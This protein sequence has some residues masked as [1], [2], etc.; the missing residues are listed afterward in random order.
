MMIQG[1][2]GRSS[3]PDY[4][5]N[6]G[7]HQQEGC[8]RSVDRG[9]CRQGIE[10]R[11]NRDRPRSLRPLA[12]METPRTGTGRPHQRPSY[13]GESGGQRSTDEVSELSDLNGVR[14]RTAETSGHRCAGGQDRPTAVATVLM[15]FT[16]Q[17]CE[18]DFMVS[19]RGEASIKR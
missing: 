13:S 8:Q 3:A 7:A 16:D 2:W 12:C 5:V 6:T 18:E 14:K 9:K 10:L 15:G 1:R 17:I 11:N 19:P 4:A